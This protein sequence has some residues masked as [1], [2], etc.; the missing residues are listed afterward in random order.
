MVVD[1][2]QR[3]GTLFVTT[4]STNMRFFGCSNPRR[5]ATLPHPPENKPERGLVRVHQKTQENESNNL[6]LLVQLECH[7]QNWCF[8]INI[9]FCV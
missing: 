6:L 1:Y 3:V 7:L 4:M 5:F 8:F 2:L 9:R